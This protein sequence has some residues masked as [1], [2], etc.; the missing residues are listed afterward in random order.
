[1]VDLVRDS[2]WGR[3]MESIGGED[4]YLGQVF[5]RAMIKAQKDI[6]TEKTKEMISCV[7]HFAAYGAVEAGRDYNTVDMSQRE[8]RQYYLPAYK[9]AI[10]S[11]AEMIMTSFNIVNGIPATVNKWLLKDLL[12]N[13]LG[14]KGIVISDYSAIEET[15]KHGVSEDKKDAAYKAIT[16]GVDIDMMSNVYAGNLK[17]LVEE[18][19]VSEELIDDAVLRVLRLKNSLGLFENPY[20]NIDNREENELLSNKENL[21]LARRLTTKTI[22][23]LKNENNILPLNHK[24]KIALI[25]PYADNIAILGSW[26]MFSDKSKI[27]TLK[28][29]FEAKIGKENVIYAKG[30]EILEEREINQILQSDG[31]TMIHTEN[32]EEKLTQYLKEAK[33]AAKQADVIVLAIGEHYRQSGEACSRANID[34]SNIQK[35]LL[36]ELAKLNKK[37]VA[38]MFNGRPIVLRDISE[39]VNGLLEAWFPGTEGANAITDI[40]FG[41]AN[42]SAK[43]T[44]SF[45]QATG[46]CP[47]YYNHYNTGRPH[48]SNVR[49]VSRY[50]DIPTESYYPFGY[51]LSYS[52]FIYSCLNLSNKVLTKDSKI[53]VSVKIKNDSN[54]I[55][56]EIVQL[57]IQDLVA[58]V[59]RPVK[60]LKAF[61]KV[62]IL[63][64]QEKEVTF[65]ISE[66]MLKFWD[67]NLRYDSENGDFKVY[68]GTNSEDTLFDT[69]SF[70]K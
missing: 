51:G 55:G 26:S 49:Y 68:I 17:Q 52:K 69:F 61:Q 33:E 32:E 11:G 3:V 53:K 45:P 62:V 16:A 43:L 40:I 35:R 25:G 18:K 13:E 66:D 47:I 44:M 1:M 10:D 67:E 34:I 54:R 38:I 57:Y 59:V 56:E 60:E 70:K 29:A 24:Q 15:I 19:L 48:E 7:K 64:K 65:E 63:P 36:N 46:Q 6:K 27:T 4:P 2:R 14:F 20:K 12:R 8:F 41:D 9:E 5:A 30:S 58:K 21:E 37:I 50:Q 23:L 22:V 28:E 39:K 31:G 42:P